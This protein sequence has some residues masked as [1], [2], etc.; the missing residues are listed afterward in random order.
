M[1]EKLQINRSRTSDRVGRTDWILEKVSFQSFIKILVFFH[2][3]LKKTL[4]HENLQIN[5]SRSS[6]RIGRTDWIPEKVSFQSFIKILVFF[7][8]ALKKN[9]NA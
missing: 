9:L 7:H 1:H 6:D 3:A 2:T 8:D 5:R 4:M